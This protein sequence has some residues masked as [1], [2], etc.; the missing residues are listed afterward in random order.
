MSNHGNGIVVNSVIGNVV[1]IVGI[2]V[3]RVGIV[4]PIVGIVVPIVGIVVLIVG[5][6]VLIVGIVVL[7]IGIVVLGVDGVVL[8]VSSSSSRGATESVMLFA[9]TITAVTL[10]IRTAV[11][12]RKVRKNGVFILG[13]ALRELDLCFLPISSPPIRNSDFL[14]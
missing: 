4:V 5:I 1:P 6:V 11:N 14:I 12:T 7:V 10:Q 13:L 8:V 3:N 9:Q 2:V